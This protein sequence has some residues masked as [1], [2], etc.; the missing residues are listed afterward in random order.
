MVF[1]SPSDVVV[2]AADVSVDPASRSAS[3]SFF[4]TYYRNAA[5]PGINWTGNHSTCNAGTTN[6]DF[7]ASVLQ[8]IVYYRAMAG[9]STAIG[10][11]EAWNASTQDAALMF[12][13]N[14]ALSHTPP[15][16][17]TCYTESGASAAGASNIA[18]GWHGR[19]AVDAYVMDGG[20]NNAPVGHRRW[21]LHP[22]TQTFG[23]GDVPDVGSFRESNALWVIGSNWNSSGP[24]RD[25]FVAWPPPGYVPYQVVYPRWSFSY[26]GADF[27]GASVQMTFNG[28]PVSITLESR[29]DNGYGLNTIVW[30][31]SSMGHSSP[32]PR[33]TADS[34]YTIRITNVGGVSQPIEYSVT[35]FDPDTAGSSPTPTRTATVTATPTRTPTVTPTRTPS[36]SPT[37][38][39]TPTLIPG[40]FAP[41]DPVRTVVNLNLRSAPTTSAPVLAV[42]VG[43]AS[44]TVTGHPVLAGGYTW[45]PVSMDGYP[46]GWVAGEYLVSNVP[47]PTATAT[48]TPTATGTATRTPTA[49]RTAT[50]TSTL[51]ATATR[52]ATAMPSATATRTP[53][54]V[55]SATATTSTGL[56]PGDRVEPVVNL[57]LRSTP[58]TSGSV[59]GVLLPGTSGVVTGAL[60]TANGYVWAPVSMDGYPA[61]WVASQYLRKTGTGP[62][63]TATRTATARPPTQTPTVAPGGLAINSTARTVA[64]LN[65]RTTPSLSG[66]V[67]GVIPAGTTGTVL[68]GPVAANGYSWYRVS[69]PGF[70]TGWVAGDYLEPVSGPPPPTAT[71]PVPTATS[72][73]GPGGFAIGSAVEV[74]VGLNL[75]SGPSTASSVLAVLPG[76]TIGTVT[77]APVTATGYT[78]YPVSM[79]GFPAGWVAGD[80]LRRAPVN[81]AG[82]PAADPTEPVT[83]T[84]AQV[85]DTV[86]SPTISQTDEVLP[87]ATAAPRDDEAPVATDGPEPLVIVRIQRTENASAGDLL[88]DRDPATVWT[89]TAESPP[90]LAAFVL[91][92]DTVQP[93]GELRWQTGTEGQAGV[94]YLA[95]S[96]DGEVWTD[97]GVVETGEP[98]SWQSLALGV[99]GRYLRFAF[100]N[101]EGT[102]WLGGIAE[103]E[104][105]P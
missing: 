83:S 93:L 81:A 15:R 9:V 1:P 94:L 10:L 99:E 88:V 79:P 17:W 14:N 92:L 20:S 32:W 12:S 26:P 31:P 103:V 89:A 98:E 95:V 102:S 34:T 78:W 64:N 5:A 82:V 39:S 54:S 47:T 19:D 6:P 104:V 43:G 87:S 105:W 84:D 85:D 75:R 69:M 8:R 37:P 61:G 21:L 7:R 22:P 58:S 97:L 62:V 100:V 68:G 72:P 2:A 57:N 24:M 35:V 63:P 18:I 25:G 59:L 50:A 11:S 28:T 36:Q 66:G 27:S 80:Y 70:S 13:S 46:A 86:P 16:S 49:T 71:A 77:G 76:G 48:R 90:Q 60:V 52:T 3:A 96:S 67:L 30:R 29:A 41:G 38:S 65:L 56:G 23:T 40:G 45:Y 73:A 33:P 55:P 91:D 51:A 53:T 74:I 42:V 4:N 44:G 101:I